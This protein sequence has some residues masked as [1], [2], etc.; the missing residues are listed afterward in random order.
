MF[1]RHG[2]IIA[3]EPYHWL[4]E[5][6]HYAIDHEGNISHMALKRNATNT[7]QRMYTF[8]YDDDG[9]IME[10]ISYFPFEL[11]TEWA[12]DRT[13]RLTE[14]DV[15]FLDDTKSWSISRR[16]APSYDDRGNVVKESVYYASGSP[17]LASTLEYDVNG[18]LTQSSWYSPSFITEGAVDLVGTVKYDGMGNEIEVISYSRRGDGTE[19]SSTTAYECR[20]YNE[21]SHCT[22]RIASKVD[23][24]GTWQKTWCIDITYYE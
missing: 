10:S 20:E 13:G 17:E 22:K 14:R 4:R 12:Y 24:Y 23:E 7:I 9:K 18:R 6:W 2:Q 5:E 1:D 8:K 11:K 16:F 15:Y 3:R 19:F 21:H